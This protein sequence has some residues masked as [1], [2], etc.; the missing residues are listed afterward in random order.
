MA[1]AKVEEV[2]EN[3]RNGKMVILFDDEDRENEGD[4]FMAVVVATVAVNCSER[5]R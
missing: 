2:L 3:L 4:L 5:W 1:L